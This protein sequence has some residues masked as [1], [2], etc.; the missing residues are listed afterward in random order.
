MKSQLVEGDGL[1]RGEREFLGRLWSSEE[2]PWFEV[3]GRTGD[4]L[5]RPFPFTPPPSNLFLFDL[6]A[7][8]QPMN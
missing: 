5:S 1:G 7:E 4:S 6:G 3:P 2:A 8:P